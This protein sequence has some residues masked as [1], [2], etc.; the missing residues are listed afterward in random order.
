LAE[1]LIVA[2]AAVERAAGRRV[3]V[4]GSKDVISGST[5]QNGAG[6][7]TGEHRA[8]GGDRVPARAAVNDA[9]G[10]MRGIALDR[11]VPVVT[12]HPDRV[13]G[14]VVAYR[15]RVIAFAAADLNA[16]HDIIVRGAG[17]DQGIAAHDGNVIFRRDQN[18]NMIVPARAG[19][20]QLPGREI[21][22]DGHELS[23]LE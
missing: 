6:A 19:H 4:F 20:G 13:G 5:A 15:D 18:L 1:E 16:G 17:V 14:L 9:A 21:C 12:A 11:V 7:A 10:C 3:G 8:D 23:G 2:V 22:G